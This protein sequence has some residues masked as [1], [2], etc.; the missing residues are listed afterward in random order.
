VRKV[1][2]REHGHQ[3]RLRMAELTGRTLGKKQEMKKR[4]N[5]EL[6]KF[7][8]KQLVKHNFVLSTPEI[9]RLTKEQLRPALHISQTTAVRVLKDM[10]IQWQLQQP[11]EA[12]LRQEGLQV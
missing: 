1:V 7:V 12:D 5:V 3:R 10:G 8:Y 9:A 4:D 11:V 6:C 2:L